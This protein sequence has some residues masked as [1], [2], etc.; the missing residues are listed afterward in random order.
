MRKSWMDGNIKGRQDPE[1]REQLNVRDEALVSRY[2]TG[3]RASA[4]AKDYGLTRERVRQILERALG[5]RAKRRILTRSRRVRALNRL[6][7][8]SPG[9]SHLP[10]RDAAG[11]VG[12]QPGSA[13]EAVVSDLRSSQGSE[14]KEAASE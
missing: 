12:A 14:L 7:G 3:E 5:R 9:V 4:L 2:E 10:V 6:L 11:V 13:T 8:K 1:A